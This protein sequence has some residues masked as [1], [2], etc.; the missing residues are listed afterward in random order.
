[1]AIAIYVCLVEK[2][3]TLSSDVRASDTTKGDKVMTTDYVQGRPVLLKKSRGRKRINKKSELLRRPWLSHSYGS[4]SPY[5]ASSLI[6]AGHNTKQTQFLAKSRSMCC[7]WS[8]ETP[9]SQKHRYVPC[10]RSLDPHF[11][12]SLAPRITCFVGWREPRIA[13]SRTAVERIVGI[14]RNRQEIAA[15]G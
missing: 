4:L 3:R 8:A 15:S 13:T 5:L 11:L 6:A 12:C 14:L 7:G 2:E 9:S 1:M 10:F